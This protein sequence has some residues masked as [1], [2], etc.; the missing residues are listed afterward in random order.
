[1]VLKD[2]F[3]MSFV[4]VT[5]LQS[6]LS[7]QMFCLNQNLLGHTMKRNFLFLEKQQIDYAPEDHYI[8][9]K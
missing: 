7:F 6:H 5:C 9:L 1:M 8:T 3:S 4:M 2:E